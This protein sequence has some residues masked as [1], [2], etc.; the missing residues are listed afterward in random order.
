M[1]DPLPAAPDN[2]ASAKVEP[3]AGTTGRAADREKIVASYWSQSAQEVLDALSSRA[4]GLT[5]SEVAE[6]LQRYGANAVDEQKQVAAI[7]LLLHQFAS[8]LVLILVFAATIS[9]I[10]RDWLDAAI[11]LVIVLGSTLLGFTQEYRASAAVAQ[12]RKRLALTV[13]VLRDGAPQTLV[14]SALVP[15]DVVELSADNLV[16]ADGLILAARDFLVT[17]ASLTG[18][19][20]PVE[21]QPGTVNAESSFAGRT[22]CAFMGTSVRSGTA[23]V[24]VVKTGRSTAFGEVAARLQTRA[25]DTEFTRGVRQFGYLLLR[26]MFV[27]V[28]FVLAVNQLLGRP[29]LESLLFAV[30]LAVGISPELL[31]AI[32]SVTLAR[33]ARAMAENGVIVRRLEAIEDLGSMDRSESVV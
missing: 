33:G 15:G 16:P 6:R 17:E 11:I 5:A 28:F 1:Q 9:L 29:A 8:P 25:T 3:H 32:V 20:M 18:E 14:T 26:I 22:N 30:A 24:V 13:R 10:V 2:P 7:R 31:P 4:R 19:S 23:T 12:L 21:K 27:M